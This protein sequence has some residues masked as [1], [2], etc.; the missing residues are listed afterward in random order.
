MAWM[1]SSMAQCARAWRPGA[2]RGAPL[3]EK[4][5]LGSSNTPLPEIWPLPTSCARRSLVV[6]DALPEHDELAVPAR[7]RPPRAASARRRRRCASPYPNLDHVRYPLP[8]Q[9]EWARRALRV[10]TPTSAMKV[11]APTNV[12]L[13]SRKAPPPLNSPVPAARPPRAWG[14]VDIMLTRRR[15]GGGLARAIARARVCARPVPASSASRQAP[16]R[17]RLPALPRSAPCPGAFQPCV[18]PGAHRQARL[19]SVPALRSR[20]GHIARPNACMCCSFSSL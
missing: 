6:N 9:A 11:P 4:V 14:R 17:R 1:S 18:A 12:A 13:S 15:C 19:C 5:P 8:Y 10:T 20:A 2:A 16:C 3:P 7:A